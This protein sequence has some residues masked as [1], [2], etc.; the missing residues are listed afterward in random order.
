MTVPLTEA[1]GYAAMATG[2]VA[3]ILVSANIGRQITGWAFVVFTVSSILWVVV[4][5]LDAEPPLI[6]QNAVLTAV[7]VFGV[8]RWLIKKAPA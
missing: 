4:G 1:I 8:Y 5:G 2:I 3:A 7:N 6:I